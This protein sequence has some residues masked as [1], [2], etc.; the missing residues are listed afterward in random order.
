MVYELH[1]SKAFFFFKSHIVQEKVL[2]SEMEALPL[3]SCVDF[4]SPVSSSVTRILF[5]TLP[6]SRNW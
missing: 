4:T 2:G 5:P 6:S 1:L 3:R